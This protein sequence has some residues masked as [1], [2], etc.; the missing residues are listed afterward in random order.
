M[1]VRHRKKARLAPAPKRLA[2]RQRKTEILDAA[3]RLLARKGLDGFSLEAAAREA[4]VAASLPRHY[5]GGVSDLLRAAVSDVIRDVE[6][7]MLSHDPALALEGRIASYLDLLERHP[8]AHGVWM[9]ASNLHPQIDALVQGAR[10][11]FAEDIY[12]TPWTELSGRQQLDAHGRIGHIETVVAAWLERRST[13]RTVVIDL[14][15]STIR[16]WAH[17]ARQARALPP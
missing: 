17:D 13:G 1:N 10:R 15:A 3:L 8:W 11:R 5:F 16:G 4:R 7:L 9:R 2:P 12:A 14:L 6:R